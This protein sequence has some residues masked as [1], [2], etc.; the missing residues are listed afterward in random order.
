MQYSKISTKQKP[1]RDVSNYDA[2]V[3]YI[4]Q[5]TFYSL[6]MPIMQNW[7]ML[8]V[9]LQHKIQWLKMRCLCLIHS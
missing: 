7:S 5:M 6:Y 3:E 4:S 8:G 1:P 2:N 9:W